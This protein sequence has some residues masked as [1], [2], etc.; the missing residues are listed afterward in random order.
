MI[1]KLRNA[2]GDKKFRYLLVGAW[3]TIFGYATFVLL[4]NTFET[5]ASYLTIALITHV[6]AVSQSFLTHREIVFKSRKNIILEYS[7]FHI[8]NISSLGL[9]I[10][11]LTILVERFLL[12]P[13][14][15]Q[16]IITAAIVAISYFAHEKYT[17]KQINEH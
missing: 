10:I 3:N 11:A 13:L 12:P 5:K 14:I 17:F 15:A 16:A 9:G 1:N 2:W 6:V 4:F 7:K 8:T